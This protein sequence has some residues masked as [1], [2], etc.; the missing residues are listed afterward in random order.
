MLP[1]LKSSVVTKISCIF[2]YFRSNLNNCAINSHHISHMWMLFFIICFF[3]FERY[4]PFDQVLKLPVS[5]KLYFRNIIYWYKSNNNDKI[6][7]VS[8]TNNFMKHWLLTIKTYYGLYFKI[9]HICWITAI[10]IIHHIETISIQCILKKRQ[11]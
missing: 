3:T 8:V 6:V 5:G 9:F 7:L 10:I 1:E 2:P 11:H 4:K